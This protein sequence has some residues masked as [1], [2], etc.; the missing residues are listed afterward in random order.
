MC[1]RRVGLLMSST[2]GTAGRSHQG[3]ETRINGVA[4]YTARPPLWTEKCAVNRCGAGMVHDDVPGDRRGHSGGVGGRDRRARRRTRPEP[5]RWS[6]LALLPRPWP[7]PPVAARLERRR[8]D[9]LLGMGLA[10]PVARVPC[11]SQAAW[12]ALAAAVR[13]PTRC[14]LADR[15]AHRGRALLLPVC[16]ALAVRAGWVDRAADVVGSAG[17]G[18]AHLRRADPELAQALLVPPLLGAR[19]ALALLRWAVPS[20]PWRTPGRRGRRRAVV[21]E[22]VGTAESTGARPPPGPARSTPTRA[23]LRGIERDLHDGTQARSGG[24]RDSARRRATPTGSRPGA[25][26]H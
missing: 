16:S 7:C 13:S 26:G 19:P 15:D 21:A 18:A 11:A 10:R 20:A 5:R 14:G 24:D 23:E 4:G 17:R 22:P 1:R 12:L 25:G 3:A 9:R 6:A 2:L 8:A